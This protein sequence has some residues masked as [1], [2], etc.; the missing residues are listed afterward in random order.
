MSRVHVYLDVDGV[1]NA[2]TSKRTPAWGW[3]ESEVV[4]VNGFQIRYSPA[5][6]ARLN[7]LAESVQFFWLTTWLSDAPRLLCP[8]LGLD[9][10]AWPVLDAEE[11][12]GA[13]WWKLTA[14][15]DHVNA[16]A[17]EQVF[18]IDDDISFDH[19]AK[20]WIAAEPRVTGISPRTDVGLTTEGLGLIETETKGAA[21]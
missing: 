6:I 16:T 2:V 15:R 5:M 12:P 8:Q 9:G 18:W 1:L 7:A 4:K 20:E 10:E 14:I 13:P 17:P 19:M 11:P 21:A 3:G